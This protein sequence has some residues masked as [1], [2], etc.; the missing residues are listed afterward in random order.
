MKINRLSLLALFVLLGFVSASHGAI[1]LVGNF[2]TGM[3]GAQEVRITEDIDFTITAN[4]LVREFV[5]VDWVNSSDGGQSGIGGVPGFPPQNILYE[6]EG[7]PGTAALNNITD[8]A[9]PRGDLTATDG[10][11]SISTF[12]PSTEIPVTIGQTLTLKAATYTFGSNVN[13]NSE[14]VAGFF[15]GDMFLADRNGNRLSDN[16]FVPIPE[17]S[18]ALLLGGFACAFAM[19]LRRRKAGKR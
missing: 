16:T 13:F 12:P 4:G 18:S 10:F 11:I 9:I 5:F 17:P 7:A 15:T 14:I 6:L 19:L 2:Q 1:R 3:A 8:N